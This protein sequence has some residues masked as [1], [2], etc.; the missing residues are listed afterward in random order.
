MLPRLS[1]LVVLLA[2]S[3]LSAGA[4][5]HKAPRP[6][7]TA[8]GSSVYARH[9]GAMQFAQDVAERHQL[10]PDWVRQTIGQAR[11]LPQVPPLMLPANQSGAKNW[12]LYRS[13]FVE[14]VRIRAGVRF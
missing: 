4:W 14:P 11:F 12:Q 10:D 3:T 2:A 6:T 9:A 7:S 8:Q 13:R 1:H 5:A